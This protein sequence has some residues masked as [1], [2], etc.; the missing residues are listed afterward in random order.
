M[1]SC[2]Q[3]I[4]SLAG[5]IFFSE[6][7]KNNN[8]ILSI[9]I[10]KNKISY[11]GAIFIAKSLS[12]NIGLVSIDISSNQIGDRGFEVLSESL[13]ATVQSFISLFEYCRI[14]E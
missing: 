14:D 8:H 10:S 7:I 5:A 1:V 2:V 13:N 3:N 4:E 9:N 12:E 11:V 6:L